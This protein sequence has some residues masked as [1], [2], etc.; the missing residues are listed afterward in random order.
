[1]DAIHFS[2][3]IDAQVHTS[4]GL[5]LVTDNLLNVRVTSSFV[6]RFPSLPETELSLCSLMLLAMNETSS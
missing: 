1:M 6:N 3:N 5:T 2:P 4:N